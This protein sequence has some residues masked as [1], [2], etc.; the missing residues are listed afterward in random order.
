MPKQKKL[1]ILYS[2]GLDSVIMLKLAKEHYPDYEIVL[3]YYDIGQ[4]YAFKELRE[5]PKGVKIR[6]V[7]WLK[8]ITKTEGKQSFGKEGSNSGD[9]IIPGR[10]LVLAVLAAC[11]EL[12]DEIWIGAL[13][14][15]IHAQSTDKNYEFL[16][17]LNPVLEYVLSPFDVKPVVKFPL[18]DKKFGKYEAVQWFFKNNGSVEDYLKS[19][20]CLS[21]EDGK[22]GHC[23]VCFR[24]WGILYHQTG[25]TEKYNN[26]PVFN[27]SE[28]NKK[29]VAAMLDGVDGKPCHY[30]EYRRREIIPALRNLVYSYT[31]VTSPDLVTTQEIRNFLDIQTEV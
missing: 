3:C 6:Y 16:E 22:C 10:N 18:A 23:V 13:Q 14:G 5:L 11:Q 15:E 27:I 2:G 12:P 1:V 7:E 4:P 20:S 28:N 8:P 26:H 21:G 17:K 31:G 30:D 19:S 25:M 29:M 24:R 9:I